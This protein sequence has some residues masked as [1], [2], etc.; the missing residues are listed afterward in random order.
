M[1]E[2]RDDER[3]VGSAGGRADGVDEAFEEAAGESVEN[4]ADDGF[5]DAPGG[6]SSGSDSASAEEAE[7]LRSELMRLQDELR[8]AKSQSEELRDRFMRARAD[9]ENYRKRAAADAERARDAG[10]DS[11][12]LPVLSVFDDLRRA[13]DAADSGD[14]ASIVPGVQSVLATL[15][16]NLEALGIK[17]IGNVGD[18]FDPDLHEA[19]TSVST[20]QAEKSET[21]A[22]VFQLGFQKGDRLIRPARV[23]VY[24]S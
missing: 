8:E 2:F 22:E 9:L 7:I 3:A 10:L 5:E 4:S 1:S 24:Q 20:D 16:R 21:I 11:A 19:L 13:I 12:V 23:V 17:S 18:S 14:P 15:E 6:A